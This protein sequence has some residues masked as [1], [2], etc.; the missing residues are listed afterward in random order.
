MLINRLL[1]SNVDHPKFPGISI[2]FQGCDA[3]PKCFNCHNP[4]TWDFD[5]KY[6]VPEELLI[7]RVKKNLELILENY[8]TVSLNFL[9]GEPLSETNRNSVRILS[10]FVKKTYGYR[11]ITLLYSWRR[12]IDIYFQELLEYVEYVDEF[13]LGRYMEKYKNLV[14]GKVDFPA[15]RNQLYMNREQFDNSITNLMKKFGGN[16]YANYVQL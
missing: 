1:F 16:L 4:Q 7:D 5:K 3:Y 11:V 12:P 10:E 15:S 9:G 8:E 6:F 13:V 2:Y 14:S